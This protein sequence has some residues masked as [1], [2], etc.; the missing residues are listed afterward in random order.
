MGKKAAIL[1]AFGAVDDV[2]KHAKEYLEN[3]L[4]GRR[5]N[6][7]GVDEPIEDELIEDLIDRYKQIGGVSPLLKITEKVEKGIEE[8][9]G[10]DFKVYLG[11]KFWE[12]Y[13]KDT[14]RDMWSD[15]VDKAAVVIMAP[16]L[17]KA[18]KAE[19]MESLDDGHR[20]TAGL[21]E[22][23]FVG[24][25][26]N[27]PTIIKIVAEKVRESYDSN[28]G[29]VLRIYTAHSMP[30]PALRGDSYV[31]N[32]NHSIELV[33]KELAEKFGDEFKSDTTLAFQS[34]GGGEVRWQGPGAEEVIEDA[35]GEGYDAV[36]IVP[37]GFICDHI[38]TMYDIDV[39]FKDIAKRK[40]LKFLRAESINDHPE[41]IR[42]LSERIS[43]ALIR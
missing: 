35:K 5:M 7:D 30:V 14:I 24:G 3:I 28:V 11:M 26:H 16:H 2:E 17:P 34:K 18:T 10:Y 9:I 29:K 19:Y 15:G 12:P 21:P 42:V 41:L 22:L 27:D 4:R 32:L 43:S 6:E 38:E 39:M 13:I 1:L 8:T 20:K 31:E 25:L 23:R 37:I 33:E 40:G 36:Q